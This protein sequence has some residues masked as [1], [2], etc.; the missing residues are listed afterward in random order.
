MLRSLTIQDLAIVRH[1]DLELHDGLTVITGETGAGK[2]IVVDAL[3]L[4]LG[5][6]GEASLV[7]PGAERAVLSAQFDIRGLH[8][9]Q[10][11][12]AEHA[13]GDT[14]DCLL[15]RVISRDGRS[16]A[17]CN[18]TP[19]TLQV[20][21]EIGALLIDIHGQH[22]HHSLLQRAVQRALV[23]AFG[24]LG[25]LVAPVGAAYAEWHA[26]A[27][28]LD[29][30]RSAG[31]PGTR[32]DYLRFQLE[33]LDAARI[34]PAELAR[35][36]ADHRR[37]AHQQRLVGGCDELLARLF[38]GERAAAR[39]VSAA[40]HQ[41]QDLVTI[42]PQLANAQELVAQASI[43][44][45]EAEREIDHYRDGVLGADVQDLER[46]ERRLHT[47]HDLC[48]KHRCE[49]EALPGVAGRLAEELGALEGRDAR[50]AALEQ[51]IAAA[52][53][54][55]TVAAGALTR[56][57]RENA[58]RMSV[59]ITHIMRQLGMPHASFSV[60][61]QPL[62]EPGAAGADEI[63]FMMTTNPDVPARALR[64]VASGGELSRTSLA[65]QVAT[66][67]DARVP[68]LV[69]D[70]IDT[71]IGG[72]V[73]AVVAQHLQTIAQGRQVLCVTHLAQVASAGTHH[74][75]ITKETTEGATA[76]RAEYLDARARVDEVARM[77]G[78]VGTARA[79][80]HAREL[81]SG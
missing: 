64:K 40:V 4:L 74:L 7:R 18:E 51:R 56:A 2:S 30:L 35:L 53:E 72:R 66:A 79:R 11:L 81:L 27:R 71:G 50:C 46:L 61:L 1:L 62:A 59:D 65:I 68:T 55:Y 13:L 47:L 25:P 70:E 69:Y 15:R 77:L 24:K 19:I 29:A 52:R 43:N 63:E 67:S 17:F 10:A 28:E 23:D 80:A 22:E 3:G 57:R 9:L 48:R 26:L 33:E 39:A 20:L 14:D 73:A 60:A 78:G 8:A 37:A 16:R 6:R 58:D 45:G 34:E 5:D 21:R 75:V 44:L 36:E 32:A 41:L 76:T 12:L 38:H 31:D 54:R 49:L 42:D